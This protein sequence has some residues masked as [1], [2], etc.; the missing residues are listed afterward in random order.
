MKNKHAIFPIIMS[1]LAF[2]CFLFIAFNMAIS[3]QPLWGKTMVLL[4]PSLILALVGSLAFKGKLNVRKTENLTVG[5]SIILVMAS[6]VYTLF[7]SM[8]MATTET[9]DVKYYANAYRQIKHEESVNGIFP[10][11]VPDDA[12]NVDFRYHPQ[13]LQGGEVFELSYSTTANILSDWIA[14][15]SDK[16]EWIGTNE[17]WY[18]THWDYGDE[19]AV[20]Y[21]LYWEDGN[22]GKTAYVLVDLPSNRITFF[23]EDW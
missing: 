13:F 18:Q 1:G 21:Q 20:R 6:F 4:L 17:E 10:E 9:T 8:C 14:F 2:L 22:H 3:V 5:L 11:K 16:V 12:E 23:Y 19:E 7:L 15:L